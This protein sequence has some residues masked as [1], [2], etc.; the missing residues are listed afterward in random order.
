MAKRVVGRRSVAM[1]AFIAAAAMIGAAAMLAGPMDLP[2]IARAGSK[3][4]TSYVE[5]GQFT[6]PI[7]RVDGARGFLLVQAR[8]AVSDQSMALH[9][10][11]AH[12]VTRH[13]GLRAIYSLAAQGEIAVDVDDVASALRDAV[14][15]ALGAEVVD[16]VYVDRLLIQ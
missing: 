12:P 9:V 15:H 11:T 8:A 2:A 14:N 5:L 16:T 3:T 13:A 7:Q 10:S 4:E 1:V 6:A